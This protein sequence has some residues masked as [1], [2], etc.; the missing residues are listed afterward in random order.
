MLDSVLRKGWTW[1]KLCLTRHNTWIAKEWKHDNNLWRRPLFCLHLEWKMP[2]VCFVWCSYPL[3]QYS[4][5]FQLLELVTA[6]WVEVL[7]LRIVLVNVDAFTKLLLQLVTNN[8]CLSTTFLI[9]VGLWTFDTVSCRKSYAH[10]NELDALEV[11]SL[12]WSKR[13]AL[14]EAWKQYE[15]WN[16][17]CFGSTVIT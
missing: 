16:S 13:C 8:V 1:M 2:S 14:W 9:K 11:L 10:V 3:I 12:L 5:L 4:Y 15:L 17:S 7:W 6:V